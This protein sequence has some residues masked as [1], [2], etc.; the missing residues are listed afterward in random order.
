MTKTLAPSHSML[1]GTCTL[2]A[3]QTTDFR[4]SLRF[5]P[6]TA[7][8]RVMWFWVGSPWTGPEAAICS[9]P[10]I[11]AEVGADGAHHA[12]IDFA[13][14]LYVAGRSD[15]S[16]FPT[17]VG[18]YD[19]TA[20]GSTDNFV[21]RYGSNTI[22][23]QGSDIESD[24]L[25][26]LG[27]DDGSGF[28][29]TD[30]TVYGNDGNL[31]GSATWTT[32]TI[33]GGLD[34]NYSDGD[35]YVE[36]P[37]SASLENVQEGNYTLAA[38]FE[39][40][41]QPPGTGSDNDAGYGVL[42]KTGTHSGIRYTY[43]KTFIVEHWLAGPTQVYVET[44][45]TFEPGSFYHV[46]S[47]VNRAAGTVEI[48]VDGQLEG[49]AG[50]A[51]GADAFDYGAATW[52]VGVA[53]P[54]AGSYRWAADGVV[55]DVRIYG[56]ALTGAEISA[57][58]SSQLVVDTT[59]DITDGDTSS[60][61]ALLADKGADGFISLREAILAVNNGSGGQELLLSAGNLQTLVGRR[62]R[63]YGS[64]GRSGYFA[65]R[66]AHRC[67][68]RDD[69]YRWRRNRSCVRCVRIEAVDFQCH[70]HRWCNSG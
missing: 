67:R 28:V 5:K 60:V 38:W 34:L 31:L 25:L 35:D 15:S 33:G 32:G 14:N 37:N 6:R 29:A 23:N 4:S 36:V 13:G 18:A 68:C 17:T 1:R 63:R 70:H 12:A 48:Y 45:N 65:G 44:A 20:N 49:S 61:A 66:H 57:V 26:H 55:D 53:D 3:R 58:A 30:H 52:K 7:V 10:P 42:I 11:L 22:S 40:A 51:P 24:L 50:F 21:A 39:P 41:T 47:V 56:R 19:T 9:L 16:D 46:A 8:E 59:M 54:A 2:W 69:H 64:R 62:W 27:L 43:N